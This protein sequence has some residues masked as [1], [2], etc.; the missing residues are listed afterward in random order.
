[1]SIIHSRRRFRPASHAETY[2]YWSHFSVYFLN[3]SAVAD[4]IDNDRF[5]TINKC[6]RR[7]KWCERNNVRVRPCVLKQKRTNKI[8]IKIWCK[9]CKYW[10]NNCFVDTHYARTNDNK[11]ILVVMYK[12]SKY[13]LTQYTWSTYCLQILVLIFHLS[14]W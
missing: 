8:R 10:R 5:R 11:T 12:W 14:I 3:A 1:M 6:G 7:S 2:F 4:W 9:S 13:L